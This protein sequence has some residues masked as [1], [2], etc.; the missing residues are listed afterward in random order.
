LPDVENPWLLAR[1]RWPDVFQAISAAE[2]D[3]RTDPGIFDLPYDANS[4]FVTHEEAAVIAE[5]WGAD[6][7]GPLDGPAPGPSLIRRMPANWSELSPAVRHAWLIEHR[8]AGPQADATEGRRPR[9]RRRRKEAATVVVADTEAVI[10]LR[11][12]EPEDVIDL[13]DASDSD[14]LATAEDA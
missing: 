5:A 11:D 10:V 3:W 12:V 7:P 14:A 2:P 4:V 8:T 1:V 9:W 6:L 13:T